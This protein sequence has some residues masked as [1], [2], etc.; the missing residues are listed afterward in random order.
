M[1]AE[2]VFY[3]LRTKKYTLGSCFFVFYYGLLLMGFIL[4][5]GQD[6]PSASEATLKNMG[7]FLK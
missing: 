3:K 4:A 5:P 7:K 6:C 1:S 2:G